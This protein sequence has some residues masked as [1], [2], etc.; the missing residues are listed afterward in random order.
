MLDW[1]QEQ[2]EEISMH[3][4]M[5]KFGEEADELDRVEGALAM[6]IQIKSLLG[7]L[8]EGEAW[9]IVHNCDKCGLEAWRKLHRRCD[10]MTGGRRRNMLRA[11][12]TPA[13]VKLEEVGNAL[14]VWEE[15][16][17]R[18]ERRGTLRG[19]PPLAEDIKCS[20]VEGMMPEELE[21]HLQ[22]NAARLQKYQ[23]MRQEI[24]M[25]FES[26]AGRSLRLS[27]KEAMSHSGGRPYGHKWS[28]QGQGEGQTADRQPE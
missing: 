21:R 2:P 25:F 20:A 23:E 5:L 16:V 27:V 6:N 13:R 3:D 4:V 7:H 1:A 19:E 26:R 11:I 15:M 8:T 12:M 22:M 28:E 14:Q 9:N 10:P 18:Y 24:L 17:E